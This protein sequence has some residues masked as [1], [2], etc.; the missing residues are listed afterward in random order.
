[1]ARTWVAE[2]PTLPD[3]AA[4]LTKA[5]GSQE[6]EA[7]SSPGCMLDLVLRWRTKGGT[8]DLRPVIPVDR[9][10]LLGEVAGQHAIAALAEAERDLDRD[11]RRLH[12]LRHLSLVIGRIACAAL[13]DADA[14]EGDRQLVA[15]GR[16]AR[17]ADRHHHATPIGVLAGNRR[18]H[19]R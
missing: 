14:V 10:I 16:L 17:L 3:R 8:S 15:I 5:K 19:Q 12:R 2:N 4:S 9:D 1:M 7:S 11:L 6:I 18:L 13:G